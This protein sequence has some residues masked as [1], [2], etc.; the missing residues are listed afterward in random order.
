MRPVQEA[1]QPNGLQ[2]ASC[3]H[4]PHLRRLHTSRHPVCRRV[5]SHGRDHRQGPVHACSAVSLGTHHGQARGRPL[6]RTGGT[7]ADI[8]KRL[9]GAARGPGSLCLQVG[10]RSP[11]PRDDCDA[12]YRGSRGPGRTVPTQLSGEAF[13]EE[14][15]FQAGRTHRLKWT[16]QHRLTLSPRSTGANGQRGGRGS[17]T[18]RGSKVRSWPPSEPPRTCASPDHPSRGGLWAKSPGP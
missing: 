17:W 12:H 1:Q 15:A 10:G 13:Q 3:Q 6:P 9:P 4:C 7:S 5:R 8:V 18:V 16:G 11:A 14:L 2:A